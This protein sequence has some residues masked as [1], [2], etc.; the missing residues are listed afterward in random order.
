MKGKP[1]SDG[2][3]R[4][5]ARSRKIGNKLQYSSKCAAFP[6]QGSENILLEYKEI[7]RMNIADRIN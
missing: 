3:K 4:I 2:V 7:L 1:L 5:H 6:P